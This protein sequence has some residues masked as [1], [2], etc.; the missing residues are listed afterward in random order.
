MKHLLVL[1]CLLLLVGCDTPQQEGGK[2]VTIADVEAALPESLTA[3]MKVTVTT[4]IDDAMET[5]VTYSIVTM[6]PDGYAVGS[7]LEGYP[8]EY[9]IAAFCETNVCDMYMYMPEVGDGYTI[10][11]SWRFF[12]TLAFYDQDGIPITTH[13][14]LAYYLFLGTTVEEDTTSMQLRYQG[15]L[16]DVYETNIENGHVTMYLDDDRICWKATIEQVDEQG[17]PTTVVY[18]LDS[19]SYGGTLPVVGSS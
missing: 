19:Y 5:I 14:M 9:Q 13:N 2:L 17:H 1:V 12:E 10:T 4:E 16:M 15:I 3:Y 8:A 7:S 6:T 18:E 11:Y